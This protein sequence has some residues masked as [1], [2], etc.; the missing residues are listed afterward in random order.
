VVSIKEGAW[1]TPD[2]GGTDTRGAAN[3]LTEDRAAPCGA[4]T[5]NSCLVQ[6]EAAR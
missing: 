4:T 5:Y 3:V 2:A 1:F 6:V